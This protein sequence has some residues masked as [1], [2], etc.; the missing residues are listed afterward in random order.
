MATL[1]IS[2]LHLTASRPAA[3]ALFQDFL[4]SRARG[5]DALYILGDL[6][7]YWIGDEALTQDE[8]RPI[9][10]SIHALTASGTPVFLMHGNRD[11][12]LGE[13]F[14]ART[15][16]RLLADPTRIQLYDTPVLLVHGDSLCTDD[17][18][19]MTFRALVRSEAWQREFL[20]KSLAEREAIGRHF[21]EQSQL[22]TSRKQLEIMDVTPSAVE[23]LMR[24]YRVR[25]MIHG[26]THRPAQHLFQ[27]DG[28]P[29]RRMVLGD[30]YE[31]GSVLRCDATGW[32]LENLPL[33]ARQGHSARSS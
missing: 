1:F 28:Q 32:V 22:S 24:E 33:P 20:G 26:H 11:F 16:C 18:E 5:A 7:E 2:D 27:L 4:G 13:E 14:A 10:A 6:F 21:R 9:G 30:W 29:A 12:L 25:D 8:F 19:Y 15:G 31:Q 3:T 17:V 23:K